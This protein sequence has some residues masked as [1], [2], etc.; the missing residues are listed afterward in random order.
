MN[1]DAEIQTETGFK[2]D[3]IRDGAAAARTGSNRVRRGKPARWRESHPEDRTNQR[4]AKT[5]INAPKRA[6][7]KPDGSGLN[8][9]AAGRPSLIKVNQ[10]SLVTVAIGARNHVHEICYGAEGARVSSPSPVSSSR[11]EDTLLDDF[12]CRQADW[13]AQRPVMQRRRQFSVPPARRAGLA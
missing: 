4:R 8:R 13:S 11:V 7:R 2:D 1:I 10:G 5:R 9:G 3:L 12:G 6:T